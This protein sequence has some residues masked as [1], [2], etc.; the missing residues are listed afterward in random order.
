MFLTAI[1]GRTFILGSSLK[2]LNMK[3]L[4]LMAL[5]ITALYSVAKYLKIS[6]FEDL[7]KLF[8]SQFK[9]LKGAVS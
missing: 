1:N 3:K 9:E 7:T 4:M 8:S 6:S 2:T 5:G